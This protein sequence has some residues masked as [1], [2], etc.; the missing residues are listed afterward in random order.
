MLTKIA[1]KF[2]GCASLRFIFVNK[3]HKLLNT[4]TYRIQKNRA[5]A[6]DTF[7]SFVCT[8][9]IFQIILSDRQ[10]LNKAFCLF[11]MFHQ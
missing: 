9:F 4:N 1:Q 2:I 10:K 7:A 3:I 5:H 11:W 8:L 6:S